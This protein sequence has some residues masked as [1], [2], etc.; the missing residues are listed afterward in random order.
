M[1]DLQQGWLVALREIRERSRSR[2]FRASLVLMVLVVVAV[3]IL[4]AM[5]DS[6][7]GTRS[8]GV[9]GTVP[10]QLPE[11]VRI[12]SEAVDISV[13]VKRYEDEAVGE[14][15]VR[16]GDIDVLIVDAQMLEWR[17]QADDQLRAI[18]TGAI[19]TVVAQERAAAAGISPQDL[20]DLVAPV[21]I[22]TAN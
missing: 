10:R 22:G 9:T 8:I 18:L 5:F 6:D 4:P 13:R 21:A 3:I 15:A 12:Q 17:T 1:N 20:R 14:E 16:R 2:A 11:A 19:Q 7:G